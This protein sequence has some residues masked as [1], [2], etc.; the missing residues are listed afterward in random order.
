MTVSDL[1]QQI[2]KNLEKRRL[3]IAEDMVD[4][5][6]TDIN[7]YHKN[8]GIAEGLMQAS[9]VIRETIKNINEEDE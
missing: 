8:V 2:R 3:E 6:M 9:E 7:A 4:G 5:R 1:L